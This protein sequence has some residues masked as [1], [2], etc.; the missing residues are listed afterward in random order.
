MRFTSLIVELIR[1][2]PVLV[3][4]LVAL[5]QAALWF[6]LPAVLYSSPPG[7]VALNLAYGREYLLGS[8]Q[9]PPLSFWLADIAFRAAGNNM[10]GVYLLSQVCFVVSLWA[11]FRLGRAIVGAQHA[12]LAVLL[13]VT[14]TAFAF[15][16]V[17]F[18]PH[19]LAQPLWALTLLSG[20]RIIGEGRRNAWFALSIHA[21]LLLLT[22]HAAPLLLA[23]LAVFALASER[24]RRMLTTFDPL[25]ALIVVVVLVLPYAM[26]A[27]RADTGW[28][29]RLPD[30][31]DLRDGLWRWLE[32]AGGAAL[33]L[34]GIA[35]L[36]IVNSR[37]LGGDEAERAPMIWRAKVD[38]LGRNFVYCFAIAPP[39]LFSILAALFNLPSLVAGTGAVL[40]MSGL[41]VVVA[42]GD[43]IYLRRQ[44]FLRRVWAGIIAAPALFVIVITLAQPWVIGS[45]V[46]TMFPAREIGAF[47]AD[48][49]QRRT[50]QPLTAVAGDPQLATLIGY[51]VP[52]RPHLLLDASPERTPWQ[53]LQR[54]NETGGVIVWRAADTAGTP[55]D[56]IARRFPG[57][58]PEVPR[59][60]QRYLMGRQ[61]LLRIGWAIVRPPQAAPP[62]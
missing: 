15:P 1:A 14:I 22:T 40:L 20:W 24:G 5:G 48:S 33:A 47:F 39:V 28:P 6:I 46:R 30:H 45:E 25:F 4:W 12:A 35:L 31:L 38:P 2:R 36:L 18:G 29:L 32:I 27:A 56:D 59:S 44:R 11:I 60:F 57:I 50:G 49:F 19:I 34:A 51:S 17:E 13:T 23:M 8:V 26:F 16:S 9:G 52:R 42:A 41:G 21:G 37:R 43:L 54:F 55:P 62:R 7:D 3:F 58:V 10:F 61:P 53:S